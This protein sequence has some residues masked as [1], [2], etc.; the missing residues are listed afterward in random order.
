MSF[1]LESQHKHILKLIKR[2][3]DKDGWATVSEALFSTL[4]EVMPKELCVFEK[5]D[6]GGRAKL[7]DEGKSIINAMKWL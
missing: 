2:D 7:T 1:K 5:L 4:S 3:A 6:N